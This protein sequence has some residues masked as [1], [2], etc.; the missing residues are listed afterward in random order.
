VAERVVAAISAYNRHESLRRLLAALARQTHPL[1]VVVVDNDS[2]EPVAPI[3]SEAAAR[4]LDVTLLRRSPNNGSAGGFAAAIRLSLTLEP[5]WIWTFDDDAEP[6]V[7]ALARLLE[8]APARAPRTAVLASAIHGSA[9][10]Q[11]LHRGYLQRR[12]LRPPTWPVAAADYVRGAP[13]KVDFTSWVGALARAEVVRRAGP[14]LTPLFTRCEDLEYFERLGHQGD[15]WLVP[16]SVVRH[17]DDLEFDGE[18]FIGTIR[19]HMAEV[20]F[21]SFWRSA[22]TLRNTI[23]WGR[24]SG[25]VN[26][27]GAVLYFGLYAAKTLAF[28]RLRMRRIVLLADYARQGWTGEL[29]NVPP[30]RWG[31]LRSVPR[32]TRALRELAVSS[33]PATAEL[34][35]LDRFQ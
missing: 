9:G 26:A 12:W 30:E 22:Y 32:P 18:S 20:P 34:V 2:S 33:E 11:L 23:Y 16:T 14:P 31:E 4:G 5:D 19:H 6:E 17:H 13:V 24:R 21:E 28:E 10:L 7:D 15:I 25:Y 27:P 35:Q 8:S 3:V 29:V 1:A